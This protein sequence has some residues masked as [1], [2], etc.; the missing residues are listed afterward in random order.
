MNAPHQRGEVL[1]T[2]DGSSPG[3][4]P[5]PVRVAATG[6]YLPPVVIDNKELLERFDLGVDAHWIETR[7][8]IRE[9]HWMSPDQT[10]SDMAA[11]VARSILESSGLEASDVDRIVLATISPDR[12]SPA[13]ATE[14][15]RKIGARCPAFD[16]SAAC[17]GFLYALDIGR[18][19]IAYGEENVLVIC[20]E[21]RSRFVNTSDRR[22]TVLFSDGAAGVLLRPGETPGLLSVAIGAEGLETRGAW[23]PAGGAAMPATHETVE[24]GL[25]FIHVDGFRDIFERFKAYTR[26]GVGMALRRAGVTLEEIDVF[27][28]HQGNAFLVDEIVAD[29]GVDPAKAIN[30]VAHHGNTSGAS[31]AIALAEARADGRIADGALVLVTAAGAGWTFGAAVL[32]F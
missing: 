29:L 17:S 16:I 32:R 22:G 30:D 9:R 11:E 24:Q 14:V 8:G 18:G 10:T 26:E 28:T 21:A 23:V 4:I 6:V 15:A 5:R 1:P 2:R 3:Q 19:A 7:T 13:T 27:I 12:L 20:A 31:V 25:H